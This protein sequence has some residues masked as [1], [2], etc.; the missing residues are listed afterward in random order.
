MLPVL[1]WPLYVED[2]ELRHIREITRLDMLD[3]SSNEFHPEG[4]FSTEIFG[5]VGTKERDSTYGKINLRV[6]I[7]TP[8]MFDSLTTLKSLYRG[9]I[10]GTEMAIFDDVEKD[11]VRSKDANASTGYSFFMA[12]FDK[13]VFT[14]NNSKKRNRL[15]TSIEKWRH[16]GT[17]KN[18]IVMPAGMRDLEID[19]S[20]R[21]VKHEINDFYTKILAASRSITPTTDMESDV[22][23]NVRKYL[24]LAVFDLYNYIGDIIFGKG[25]FI[26]DKV[27]SRRVHDGTRAVLT[28]M[29][30]S[31]SYLGSPNQPSYDSTVIGLLQGAASLAPLVINWLRE[32]HLSKLAESGDGLV[33]L[34]NGKTLLMDFVDVPSKIRDIFV[35]EDGIRSLINQLSNTQARH[36]PV[37]IGK[38]YVKLIYVDDKYFKVFDS[39][40][41]VPDG[42]DK[43]KVRPISLIELVYTAGYNKWSNFHGLV[44]R[45]PHN[46]EDSTYPTTAY[47][48]TTAVG[49]Q[50]LELYDDWRKPSLLEI[51]RLAVEFPDAKSNVFHDSLSPHPTRLKGLGADFDGD[52]GS[53]TALQSIESNTEIKKYFT[54]RQAWIGVNGKLRASFNYETAEL[55]IRNLTGRFD[56]VRDVETSKLQKAVSSLETG[57]HTES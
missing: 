49:L 37:M 25:G 41:E 1:N 53:W 11:F 24:T 32:G 21:P 4:L 5:K 34:V 10:D 19:P 45:Y 12:H 15:V 38:D 44:T 47:V 52:M 14:K 27:S 51:D 36:R 17:M 28:S 39:I 35:T 26:K 7:L 57:T 30:T 56:H 33:P 9:I 22:Y 40:D 23:D 13:I 3:G 46:N 55:V 8:Y 48:K 18:C 31:A 2:P 42:F 16:R 6:R 54:T 29:N 43:K 20:G 50:L